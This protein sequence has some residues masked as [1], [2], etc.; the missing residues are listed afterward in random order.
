MEIERKFL[1]DRISFPLETYKCIEISQGYLASDPS[2]RIRQAD[3][4]YFLTV[5]G[6][7][8]IARQEWELPLSRKQYQN[9][10]PKVESRMILKKRYLV[11]LDP[12]YTAEVDVYFGELQSL[13]TIE[14]E[15]PSMEEANA[16]M[17]PSWFGADVS[18]DAAYQNVNLARFGIPHTP[19]DI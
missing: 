6:S 15:F 17:P 16:F 7:G 4:A 10:L 14:V 11:P 1:G 19:T 13:C 9:L 3:Q 2:I 8:T 5:K 12:A 18:K